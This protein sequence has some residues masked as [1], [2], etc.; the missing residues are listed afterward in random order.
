MTSGLGYFTI[1]SPSNINVCMHLDFPSELN[2][3][4]LFS[5]SNVQL[6]EMFAPTWIYLGKSCATSGAGRTIITS[7]LTLTAEEWT[8]PSMAL[9]QPHH[10]SNTI[11]IEILKKNI[12]YFIILV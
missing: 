12:N 2:F 1:G 4:L 6:P 11:F 9:H 8:T 3:S 5:P 10:I 7:K